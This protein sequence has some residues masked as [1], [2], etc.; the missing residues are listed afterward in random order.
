MLSQVLGALAS[1][2]SSVTPPITTREPS[3]NGWAVRDHPGLPPRRTLS[4]VTRA[5]TN[6]APAASR[7]SGICRTMPSAESPS[8]PRTDVTAEATMP[9]R[10]AAMPED[11][12]L[13]AA[14]S[15]SRVASGGIDKT[16]SILDAAGMAPGRGLSRRREDR[17][18]P[19]PELRA[20]VGEGGPIRRPARSGPHI[21]SDPDQQAGRSRRGGEPGRCV[22]YAHVPETGVAPRIPRQDPQR[23]LPQVGHGAYA[24][25]GA[26]AVGDAQRHIVIL[27]SDLGR[28][29]EVPEIPRQREDARPRGDR[30]LRKREERTG[31]VEQRDRQRA[32]RQKAKKGS[33]AGERHRLQHDRR[34]G[35]RQDEERGL[36]SAAVA[37]PFEHRAERDEPGQQPAKEQGPRRAGS[38]AQESDQ[39][40][41]EQEQVQRV[42]SR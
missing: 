39:A 38:R 8:M 21:Q 41:E 35:Q 10:T 19:L 18:S 23:A 40:P 32:E 5:N 28:V 14:G 16:T 24:Y 11:S 4:L 33:S 30:R 31:V 36:Q 17:D 34:P 25:V 13:R 3:R 26:A 1:A 9:C 7:S 37:L 2:T 20:P 27:R 42:G 29:Q 6:T 15:P 12:P 22:L